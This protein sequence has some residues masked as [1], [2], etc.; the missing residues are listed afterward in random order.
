MVCVDQPTETN[1]AVTPRMVIIYRPMAE[2]E[3][4]LIQE[5]VKDGLERAKKEEKRLGRRPRKDVSE[6]SN[7]QAIE[8]HGSQRKA[9]IALGIPL[10]NLRDHLSTRTENSG[11]LA[12]ILR[13]EEAG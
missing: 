6:V 8:E 5:R 11:R 9:A 1:S 10:S 3:R 2:F 13:A 7:R 12:Y 4:E